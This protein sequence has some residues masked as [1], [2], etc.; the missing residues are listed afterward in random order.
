MAVWKQI[1]SANFPEKKYEKKY[2]LEFNRYYQNVTKVAKVQYD[3]SVSD[4]ANSYLGVE[5]KCMRSQKPIRGRVHCAVLVS[6]GQE[7]SAFRAHARKRKVQTA[8]SA[9]TCGHTH[10]HELVHTH[11]LRAGRQALWFRTS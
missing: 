7:A 8:V 6:L 5:L 4:G 9:F 11:T 3:F 2:G 10:V 1:D